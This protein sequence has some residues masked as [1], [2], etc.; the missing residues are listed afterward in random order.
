MPFTCS[1]TKHAWH[2]GRYR[3]DHCDFERLTTKRITNSIAR[4]L[5][6]LAFNNSDR[7]DMARRRQDVYRR[8]ALAMEDY[9]RRE[10]HYDYNASGIQ[11]ADIPF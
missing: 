5:D 1:G 7:R 2:D 6:P 11:D 8:I 3:M 10:T 4:S 9:Y